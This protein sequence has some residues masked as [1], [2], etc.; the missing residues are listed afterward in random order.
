[1][2]ADGHFSASQLGMLRRCEQQFAYRYALG[3]KRPPSAAMSLGSSF[4]DGIA[5]SLRQKI[6][7]GVDLP[8]P[9]VVEIAVTRLEGRKDSTEWDEPFTAV[10]DELPGLVAVF[11]KDAAPGIEPAAVE[12]KVVTRLKPSVGEP[13]DVLSY[14]DLRERDGRVTD[15]KTAKRSWPEDRPAAELQPLLYTMAEAGESA[16]RFL[17]TVRTKTPKIQVLDRAITA[18]EKQAATALVALAKRRADAIVANPEIAW[19]TGHGGNLCS[20]RFCGYWRECKARWQ[21]A[22]RD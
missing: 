20:K 14:L 19:P 7:S 13:F 4:G 2:G 5:Y 6:D 12:E 21:H 8:T 1:M 10:K 22:I 9:E 16:F 15:L 11:Q 17:I 3:L 18:D